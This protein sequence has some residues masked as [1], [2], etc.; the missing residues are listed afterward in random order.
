MS[1]TEDAERH[2]VKMEQRKAV[3]DARGRG[4]DRPRRAC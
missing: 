3:Q 1:D 2:R 4:K